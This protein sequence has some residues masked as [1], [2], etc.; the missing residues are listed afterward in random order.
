[1]EIQEYP[2]YIEAEVLALY[3]SVGWSGYTDNPGMLKN[4]FAGSLKVLA[5]YEHDTLIGIIR[6]VGDGCS[7]LYIQDLLVTPDH[8]RHGVGTALIKAA[9]ELYPNVYQTVLM[10]DDTEKTKSFYAKAGF[11]NITDIGCTGFMKINR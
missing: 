4:A 8:Q 6:L 5:A 1:M 7:I 3:K 9:L 11:C 10:T 2:A